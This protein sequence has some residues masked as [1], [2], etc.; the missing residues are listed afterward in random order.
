MPLHNDFVNN[1]RHLQKEIHQNARE[2]GFWEGELGATP[3][4]IALI[5]TEV[6]EAM[7]AWRNGDPVSAKVPPHT[8]FVEELADAVIRIMDLAA[9]NE[10]DLGLAIIY[11]IRYNTTRPRLHGG[12]RA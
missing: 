3:T 4:K 8:A 6:S 1:F 10:L 7:E 9:G 12:K 2:K 5:H 11:K